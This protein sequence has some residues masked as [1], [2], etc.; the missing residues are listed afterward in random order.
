MFYAMR[1]KEKHHLW[2]GI[3]ISSNDGEFCNSITA[4]F[5]FVSSVPFISTDRGIFEDVIA[6]VIRTEWYNSSPD[7]PELTK[8]DVKQK[9][10]NQYEL[11][12]L[13]VL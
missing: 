11:V 7:N 2:M 10:M 4:E 9:I 13:G 3:S 1:H 12:E 8:Y 6:G 5:E